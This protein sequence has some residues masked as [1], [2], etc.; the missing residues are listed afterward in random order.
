MMVASLKAWLLWPLNTS[1]LQEISLSFLTL[2]I[3]IVIIL[4][5]CLCCNC[6]LNR[7]EYTWT[8]K[9]LSEE[10]NWTTRVYLN[11]TAELARSTIGIT[12]SL[13]VQIRPSN[14]AKSWYQ[15]SLQV[16]P[17]D[18]FF[19]FLFWKFIRKEVEKFMTEIPVIVE[20]VD[21][22]KK[23]RHEQK[24]KMPKRKKGSMN[25]KFVER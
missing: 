6:N 21:K 17:G 22:R 8:Q 18:D 9:P 5:I 12:H 16:S 24:N 25:R 19:F 4:S 3:V 15:S 23:K 1:P 13:N 7:C 20:F 14:L 2:T 10:G 11:L